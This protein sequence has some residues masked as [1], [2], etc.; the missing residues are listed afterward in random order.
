MNTCSQCQGKLPSDRTG[1][2]DGL[3]PRCR[4]I[5]V[6]NYYGVPKVDVQNMMDPIEI[7]KQRLIENSQEARTIGE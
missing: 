2:S 4:M 1:T 5:D 3:C 7:D 6:I